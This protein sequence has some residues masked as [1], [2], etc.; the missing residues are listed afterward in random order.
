MEE[1]CSI[2]HCEIEHYE[3][4]EIWMKYVHPFFKGL[5]FPI[6]FCAACGKESSSPFFK[7]LIRND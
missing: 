6:R 1:N 4:G 2:A 3:N 7:N 5:P